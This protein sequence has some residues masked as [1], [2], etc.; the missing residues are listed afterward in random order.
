MHP[1][2]THI[3][4]GAYEAHAHIFASAG[5]RAFTNAHAGAAASPAPSQ[6]CA[7]RPQ[8][9][10][11]SP[12]SHPRRGRLPPTSP[13][14]L[15]ALVGLDWAEATRLGASRP[16]TLH[17]GSAAHWHPR[18]RPSTRGARRCGHGCTAPRGALPRT[19]HRALGLRRAPVCLSGALPAPASAGSAVS[20]SLHPQP[21]SR[22]PHR[23]RTAA[24]TAA[25]ASGPAP[26][27]PSPTPHPAR[28]RTRVALRRRV[29]APGAG[30]PPHQDLQ[31][32]FPQ[33]LQGFRTKTPAWAVPC[34]VAG[35]PS[36]RP[37]ARTA[38]PLRPSA[39]RITG[40]RQTCSPAPPG[41]PGRHAVD[42]RCRRHRPPCPV[43]P[44]LVAQR[45]VTVQALA[46]CDT[47]IAPRAPR[48]PALPLCPALPGAGPVCAPR[49]LGAL[50]A[51]RARDA[52]AA[53]RQTEAGLAPVTERRGKKSWGPWRLQGPK[54]L[55]QTFVA[56]AAA[57][58][59]HACWAQRSS[60]PQRAQ[61][62][63]HQAAVRALACTWL[64]LLSRCWQ[65]RTLSEASTSLQALTQRGSSRMPNLAK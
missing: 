32:S 21:S 33:V 31:N 20:C 18:P 57:S 61:G 46:D 29:R 13:D 15:A 55:R 10:P 42:D 64:R 53:A 28:P 7:A 8:A 27:A 9:C 48:P 14:T 59:R 6:A 38:P 54:F 23:R 2:R 1:Q 35:P 63:A 19:H 44:T 30:P 37:N 56:W 40:A 4:G 3:P 12:R 41:S 34:C 22:R 16:L 52:S 62:K 25:H 5:A 50:G 39:T 43:A 47:A 11:C 24:R 60:Q 65:D 17:N 58:P 45:R 49:R 26:S 51:Q 36:Q